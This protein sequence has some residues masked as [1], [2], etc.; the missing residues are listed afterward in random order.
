MRREGNIVRRRGRL[1]SERRTWKKEMTSWQRDGEDYKRNL[2]IW[3]LV[4]E[5][6]GGVMVRNQRGICLVGVR[7]MRMYLEMIKLMVQNPL[8]SCG[9]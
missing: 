7:M 4:R 3:M 9:C 8:Q 1:L 2:E 6:I 5:V